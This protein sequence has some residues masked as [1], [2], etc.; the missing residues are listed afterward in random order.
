MSQY[1]LPPPPIFGLKASED[2]SNKNGMISLD[3]I[4][5][6]FFQ[7]DSKVKYPPNSTGSNDEFDDD[8]DDDS[9]DDSDVKKRKRMSRS[10][11]RSMTEEQK[12]E[13][14]LGSLVYIDTLHVFYVMSTIRKA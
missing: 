14:R 10:M 5:E 7:P 2:Q 1:K 3:D 9:H 11:Q 13:R 6:D 12:I 4:F 8:D